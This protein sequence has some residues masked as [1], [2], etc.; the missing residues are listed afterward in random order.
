MLLNHAFM[1]YKNNTCVHLRRGPCSL[2]ET[3]AG[4]TTYKTNTNNNAVQL[5]IYINHA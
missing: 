3:M 1:S 4:R 2:S 5:Q